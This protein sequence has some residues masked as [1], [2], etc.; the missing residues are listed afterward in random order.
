MALPKIETPTFEAKLPSSKKLIKYRPFLVKEEKV[1]LI[2]N[3]SKDPKAMYNAMKDV[4]EACTFGKIQVTSITPYD[5]EYLFLK[6]RS[7]SVGE[8]SK[9][10]VKCPECG[11][12]N[13][14]DVNLEKVEVVYPTE[15]VDSKVMLTDKVGVTLKHL[16]VDD[17]AS[18][19]DGEQNEASVVT[20]AIIKSI[21]SVF[22]ENGV[23]STA[24]SSAEELNTFIESLNRTQI[25]KIN[26]FIKTTPKI[27]YVAKFKCKA[28]GKDVKVVLEG[29]NSFF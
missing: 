14:V 18:L 27:Q 6:L 29:L 9:I 21:E 16:T 26:D 4:V 10:R 19:Q 3:E 17:V 23:Y 12:Y 2:A 24:D 8:V 22:D 25:E 11:E 28:C 20:K 5:L 1:L 15:K 7:K 13:D